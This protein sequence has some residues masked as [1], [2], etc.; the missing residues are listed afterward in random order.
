MKD[1]IED[2]AR[3]DRIRYANCWE[4]ADILLEAMAIKPED[5]TCQSLQPEITGSAS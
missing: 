3:F 5:F 4:D 1:R 2:R